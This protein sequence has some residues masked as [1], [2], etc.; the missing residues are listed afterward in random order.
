MAKTADE[1]IHDALELSEEGRSRVMSALA[2]SF[3]LDAVD[4]CEGSQE[5]AKAYMA[6]VRGRID[7]VL[8]GRVKGRPW[9]EAMAN[10][11]A[12]LREHAT[13]RRRTA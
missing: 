10:L 12:E 2:D 8:A 3:E 4:E 5:D 7:D 1:V 9:R 6:E 11:D 13:R